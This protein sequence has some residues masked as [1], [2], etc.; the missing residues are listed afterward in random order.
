MKR[1][2]WLIRIR[3]EKGL[4]QEEVARLAEIERST[5]TK[6]ETGNSVSVKTAKKIAKVLGVSWVR[7]F[8]DDCAENA[9]KGA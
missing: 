8:E 4:T 7:F 2:E 6:I 3:R 5:Y 1:R 9:Q